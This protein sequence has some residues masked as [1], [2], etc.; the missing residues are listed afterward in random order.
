MAEPPPLRRILHRPAT[1]RTASGVISNGATLTFSGRPNRL[2]GTF[3]YAGILNS[4]Q[5]PKS[6]VKV[7]NVSTAGVVTGRATKLA[8]IGKR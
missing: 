2:R 7:L 1:S 8:L 4:G 5:T 3:L 6:I